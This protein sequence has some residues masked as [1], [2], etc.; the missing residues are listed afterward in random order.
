[1]NI[2]ILS[3][4]IAKNAHAGQTR[5]DG[6]TAYFTHPARVAEELRKNGFSEEYQAVAYLHDVLEDTGVTAEHLDELGVTHDVIEAVSAMT[7][8]KGETYNDYLERVAQNEIARAVKI[9]DV[10]DNL[11]DSPTERQKEKYVAAL[12]F[13]EKKS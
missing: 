5:R 6:V 2:A 7:K 11:A 10:K 4:F 12:K 9:F 13:L 1:M 8:C 3:H